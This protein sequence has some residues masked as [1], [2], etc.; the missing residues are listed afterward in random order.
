MQWTL[1]AVFLYLP[2]VFAMGQNRSQGSVSAQTFIHG[3]KIESSGFDPAS[4][5]VKLVFINDSPIDITAWGYCIHAQTAPGSAVRHGFC[6]LVDSL[7]TVIGHRIEL[8]K[9]PALPEPECHGCQLIH[10]GQEESIALD[11]SAFPEVI[12]ATVQLNLIAYSGGKY[13]LVPDQ[14]GEAA[15][16]DLA[17]RRQ[18]HLRVTQGILEVGR[19]VLADSSDPHP[20]TTMIQAIQTTNDPGM[21]PVLESFKRPERRAGNDQEFVPGNERDYV[22]RFVKDEEIW[23]DQLL[24]NQIKEVL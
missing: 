3:I 6:T 16:H 21:A 12:G 13:E 2:A 14:A 15:L 4:R 5:V 10:P 17:G 23:A 8:Q 20:A 7:P 24:R 19:R 22:Q 9:R 11:F 1:F 18:A